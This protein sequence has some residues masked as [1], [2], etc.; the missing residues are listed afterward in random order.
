MPLHGYVN[1]YEL[2]IGET[3]IHAKTLKDFTNLITVVNDVVLPRNK[4]VLWATDLGEKVE[5]CWNE[6]LESQGLS[7]N[8]YWWTLRV[9]VEVATFFHL[10]FIIKDGHSVDTHSVA[11]LWMTGNS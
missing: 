8:Y 4:I 2:D 3:Q 6:L 9:S 1:R 10:L 11:T 5:A 7:K